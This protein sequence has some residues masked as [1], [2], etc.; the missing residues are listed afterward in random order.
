MINGTNAPNQF[1]VS[2]PSISNDGR[3][4]LFQTGQF[5]PFNP[6]LGALTNGEVILRD[7]FAGTTEVASRTQG[8]GG[9]NGP[10][11][12]YESEGLR[13]APRGGISTDGRF[14]IFS[15]RATNMP[16]VGV[17]TNAKA[18]VFRRERTAVGGATTI[19][20]FRSAQWFLNNQLDGSGAEFNFSYGGASDIPISGDWD[21]TGTVTPG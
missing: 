3:Y 2:I 1:A 17:D 13:W 12:Q 9:G 21:C 18:D 7:R 4:V 10:S 16:G 19:G 11:Y 8:G 15:S 14:V 5:P 6:D 20:I